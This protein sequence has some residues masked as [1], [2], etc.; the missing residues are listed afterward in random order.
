MISVSVLVYCE[1]Y[2]QPRGG[3]QGP[4]TAP[5]REVVGVAKHRRKKYEAPADYGIIFG[6]AAVIAGAF[7][8]VRWIMRAR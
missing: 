4:D 3:G 6:I 8:L 7:M 5:R 2:L 1:R